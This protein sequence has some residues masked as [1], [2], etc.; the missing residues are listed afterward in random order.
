MAITLKQFL[1]KDSA[2]KAA[3]KKLQAARAE[4]QKQE[5]ALASAAGRLDEATRQAVQRRLDAAQLE[6]NKQ[7]DNTAMIEAERSDFFAKNKKAIRTEEREQTVAEAKQQLE[8][9]LIQ[10]RQDPRFTQSPVY[11]A[12]VKDLND[13]INQTGKYAPKPKAQ[14]QVSATATGGATGNKELR[15]YRAEQ[16]AAFQTVRNMTPAQ[17]KDLIKSLTNA[18]YNP[19]NVFQVYTDELGNEYLKAITENFN[20]SRLF[21]EMSFSEFIAEKTIESNILKQ[22]GGLGGAPTRTV[23]TD[24]SVTRRTGAQTDE[25]INEIAIK[26][27]GREINEEDKAEDWYTNLVNS[28]N[29]MY[30]KGTTTVTTMTGRGTATTGS[31]RI[32]TPAVTDADIDALIERRLRKGDPES[33]GRKERLDFVS[34]LNKS[35]GD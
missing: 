30:E 31:K 10:G 4:V 23:A 22:A 21:G 34:W 12:R 25:D 17:R 1:D 19:P 16:Q 20:R 33:V 18:G 35:L 11:I 7:Q 26:V 9:I 15:D 24:T 5:Q 27:L 8:E 6:L 2:V 14:D 13:R 28:I 29:K 32:T 3:R